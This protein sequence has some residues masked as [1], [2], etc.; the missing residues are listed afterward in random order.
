[1]TRLAARAAAVPVLLALLATSACSSSGGGP[2]A[3]ATAAAAVPSSGPVVTPSRSNAPPAGASSPTPAAAPV[4]LPRGGRSIFPRHEVVA[5]YGAEGTGRLG[6]LGRTSP[7]AAAAALEKRAAPYARVSGRKVLP[8][9]E[10]ITTVAQG[11]A[12]DD[13]TYSL[14]ISD[15]SVQRYLTAARKARMLLLLDLQPGRADFLDQARH[16]EKFLRQPEVGLALDPEWKLQPGQRPGERVGYTTTRKI[17]EVARYLAALVDQGR[18][19]Q[20]LFVVHQFQ[21]QSVRPANERITTRP[22]LA[23]VVHV[24]GFGS[25]RLKKQTYHA[26]SL[27]SGAVRNGFKLFTNG[28]DTGVFRPEQVMRLRPRPDLVTYQ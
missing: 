26:I 28:Q 10:L 11:S 7:A 2:S 5:Y 23:T 18:L 19:P 17:D 14:G 9:L 8:A 20:K 24:D 25:Q 16:Y 15:A 4:Q 22:Q 21:E 27:K 3:P 1:V 12:G 6:I 13:G